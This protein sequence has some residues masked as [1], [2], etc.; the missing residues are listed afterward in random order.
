MMCSYSA[1]ALPC[2]D[3]D[4]RAQRPAGNVP[5]VFYALW[6]MRV[7]VSSVLK[8]VVIRAEGKA[9]MLGLCLFIVKN[10][11]LMSLEPV[12]F[13]NGSYFVIKR[14]SVEAVKHSRVGL[15]RRT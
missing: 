15:L 12:F 2:P 9:H 10:R 6:S 8:K 14:K 5:A 1:Y 4:T 3:T 11:F 7:I 13:P